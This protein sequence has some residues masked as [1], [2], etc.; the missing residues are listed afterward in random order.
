MTSRKAL[1]PGEVKAQSPRREPWVCGVGERTSPPRAKEPSAPHLSPLRGYVGC[2]PMRSHGSRR[3]LAECRHSVANCQAPHSADGLNPRRATVVRNVLLLAAFTILTL[4]AQPCASFAQTTRAKTDPPTEKTD[5]PS[6]GSAL[7]DRQAIVRDRVAR[8]EDR[9]FQLSQALRKAEPE[10]AAKLLA[11]LGELR[12]RSIRQKVD[13]I[14]ARLRRGEFS[15]AADGQQAV[16]D[17]LQ[18]LLQLLLEDPDN[19]EERRDEIKQLEELRKALDGI[20]QEQ[21]KEKAA[22]EASRQAQRRAAALEEAAAR[23]K[24]LIQRQRNLAEETSKA[25]AKTEALADDQATVR[26]ETQAV[27]ERVESVLDAEAAAGDDNEGGEGEPSVANDGTAPKQAARDIE[28]ATD[29]MKSAEARL[30]KSEKTQAK[31]DQEAAADDLQRALEKIEKKAEEIRN[32]LKLDEQGEAQRETAEK[33]QDLSDDMKRAGKCGGADGEEQEP[34]GGDK[35]QEGSDQPGESGD[36]QPSAPTPGQQGVEQAV[37]LQEDAADELE[38]ENLD[39]AIEKQEKALEKLDSAKDALEDR[40]DQLRKEQ[41]EELLAA[42]ESR[43]RAM[44]ARQVACNKTTNRLAE[45]GVENW[46]RSDQ[47]ELAELSQKQRWVGEQADKALFI[48]V[49]EGTT[50]VLPQLVEQVSADAREAAD[51]L[52]AADVRETVRMMQS[53]LEQVLR[54][55]IDAIKKK[56]EDLDSSGGGGGGGNS[57]LLP[58]SAELKLL[59]ACQ[60]RVNK[61]TGR[62]REAHRASDA[63]QEDIDASLSRL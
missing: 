46:K 57:P 3:G 28:H 42:L 23:L 33:T 35:K 27:A 38:D 59:S 39:E 62:L 16:A 47:L 55:I 50:V 56:Q 48:L 25:G 15:D 20:I 5:A 9:M 22:A 6:A 21:Q 1:S 36:D 24:N 31:A 32:T 53:D 2:V 17:D 4:V 40:L 34:G 7:A 29:K 63:S 26:E 51:R 54:D 18:R 8:L 10:K 58:G 37:P 61:T 19:L 30:R 14:V 13:D 12:G 49:E 45:L 41:Q 60:L 43:F 52:A 11:G 44:L